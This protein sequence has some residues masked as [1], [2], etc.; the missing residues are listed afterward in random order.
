MNAFNALSVARKPALGKPPAARPIRTGGFSRITKWLIIYFKA[1]NLLYF[2]II[3][4]LK[5]INNEVRF[6]NYV[7]L[8][9]IIRFLIG[10]L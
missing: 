8:I 6:F 10:D 2:F 3:I 7:K 4:V 9:T 5:L 1:L